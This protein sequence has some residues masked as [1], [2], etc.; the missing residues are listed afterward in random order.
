MWRQPLALMSAVRSRTPA[1]R[2]LIE[3]EVLVY[4]AEKAQVDVNGFNVLE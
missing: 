2:V 1:R 4:L 3:R